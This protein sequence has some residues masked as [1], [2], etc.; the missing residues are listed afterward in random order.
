MTQEISLTP[1]LK[2]E[3]IRM[4]NNTARYRLASEIIALSVATTWDEAKEEWRLS[5]I[6][7]ANPDD[8]HEPETCLCGHYPIRELCYIVN[9]LKG[10]EALVGN[11]CIKSFMS[12]IPSDTIFK[13]LKRIATDPTKAM[14]YELAQH[15]HDQGWLDDKAYRFA[16]DTIHR[17]NLSANQL[18]WRLSLNR[19]VTAKAGCQAR[20]QPTA[21]PIGSQD[22][23]VA[24]LLHIADHPW[25]A[26]ITSDAADWLHDQRQ[27]NTWERNFLRCVVDRMCLSSAQTAIVQKIN[28]KVAA[29]VRQVQA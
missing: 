9:S 21:A 15:A 28:A 1:D 18:S 11:C 5:R 13:C 27:I 24:N 12:E 4:Q 25:S 26:K 19:T 14:N 22:G 29:F 6:E 17:R 3:I 16:V 23:I 7:Y 10:N 20:Q 2:L 8:G